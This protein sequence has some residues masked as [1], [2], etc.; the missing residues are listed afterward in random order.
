M[1]LEHHH[2]DAAQVRSGGDW[3]DQTIGDEVFDQRLDISGDYLWIHVTVPR[4]EPFHELLPGLELGRKGLP[5]LDPNLIQAEIRLRR[6]TEEDRSFGELSKYDTGTR[7][8]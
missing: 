6:G 8:G 4:G 3:I 1:P 7:I 5:D 2:G